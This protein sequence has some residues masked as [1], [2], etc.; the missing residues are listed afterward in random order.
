MLKCCERALRLSAP[1]LVRGNFNH[2]KAVVFFSHVDH[3]NS[4][5]I[6]LSL[7]R[8]HGVVVRYSVE[9]IWV[10]TPLGV[11]LEGAGYDTLRADLDWRRR[12]VFLSRRRCRV[13]L[14]P[15]MMRRSD[16]SS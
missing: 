6:G 5:K 10:Q 14:L 4:P 13:A 15:G 16:S 2:A 3:G 11:A 1:Q 12:Q 9:S 7:P 8:L